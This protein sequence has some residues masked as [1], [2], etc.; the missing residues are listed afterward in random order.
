MPKFKV[1][2]ILTWDNYTGFLTIVEVENKN[3]AYTICGNPSTKQYMTHAIVERH[4]K[5]DEEAMRLREFKQNL[6][7]LLK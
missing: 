4:T 5:L 7:E 6:D 1:G 3:Y 2:D